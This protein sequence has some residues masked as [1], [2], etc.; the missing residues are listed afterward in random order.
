MSE[1]DTHEFFKRRGTSLSD[2]FADVTQLARDVDT[3]GVYEPWS[4]E[5]VRRLLPDAA[6]R[7]ALP[8]LV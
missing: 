1:T 2:R 3:G 8:L 5:I 7:A 6:G 4:A